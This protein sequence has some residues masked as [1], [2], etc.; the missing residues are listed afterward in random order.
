M[1]VLYH[2]SNMT[3]VAEF[4]HFFCIEILQDIVIAVFFDVS[5]AICDNYI[6]LIKMLPFA[7]YDLMF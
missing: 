4:V 1:T 5:A 6:F 2:C 3:A 7:F